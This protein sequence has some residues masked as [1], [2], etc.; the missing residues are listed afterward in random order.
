MEIWL[1]TVDCSLISKASE[2]SLLFGV[3]TNPTLLSK[4]KD[5]NLTETL[6]SLLMSQSGPVCIQSTCFNTEDIIREA[7]AL[8]SYSKRFII[9]VMCDEKAYLA[10]PKLASMAIPFLG[11]A[12]L[13]TKQ[14][15]AAAKLEA[16]YVAPY[17]SHMGPPSIAR[18]TLLQMLKTLK[19]GNYKTK[20]L[21]ASL[22]DL[23][24]LLYCAE[25]GVDAVTLKPP[26][27]RAF[28]E[29]P[30]RLKE[31][32]SK[33]TRDWQKRYGNNAFIDLLS[34]LK[35]KAKH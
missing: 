24:D 8:N 16:D 30:E 15:L 26:L 4:A 5:D 19:V 35:V 29:A 25:I 23:E 18:K 1:D 6:N 7:K 31:F 22:H 32:S 13:E 12:V 3:T 11:T 9:K 14:V 10:M 34:E 20:L 17:F 27:Y 21:V 33:F 28:L 2:Q